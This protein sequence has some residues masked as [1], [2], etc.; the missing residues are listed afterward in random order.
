MLW[1]LIYEKVSVSYREALCCAFF[2]YLSGILMHCIECKL[3]RCL[4]FKSSFDTSELTDNLTT[5]RLWWEPEIQRRLKIY[6]KEWNFSYKEVL[7]TVGR[8][9]TEIIEKFIF[10]WLAVD[11]KPLPVTVLLLWFIKELRF[12]IEIKTPTN[13]VVFN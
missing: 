7:W 11:I 10:L 8:V 2:E 4:M 3:W 13:S 5:Q 6:H 12:S 9:P 1:D